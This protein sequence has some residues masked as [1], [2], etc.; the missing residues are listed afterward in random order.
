MTKHELS[1]LFN[2]LVLAHD[3]C[4]LARVVPFHSKNIC[5]I[6]V[7]SNISIAIFVV[8]FFKA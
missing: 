1:F 6:I 2:A 7:P 3:E 8:L 4:V 5:F